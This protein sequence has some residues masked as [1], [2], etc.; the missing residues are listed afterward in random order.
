M[1]SLQS[2][3]LPFQDKT[4]L[5][6]GGA[7]YL[8]SGLIEILRNID[9]RII[10]LH[11]QDSC[12]ASVTGAA[13]ILD[14]VGDV[15]DPATWEQS[16]GGVDYIFHFAAQTSTYAANADPVADQ[17]GNVQ[18]ML[19]LL[20]SC[21]RQGRQPVVCFAS[22]VTIAGIPASL[23]V[24]ESHPDHPLTIYDLHKLMAEQYLRWYA[25]QG[26]V[27][28]VSLRLP[29]VYGP[30]PRS[31]RADRGILNQMMFRALAGET[32]TVYGTGDQVRD[33]LYVED[34]ARAFLAAALHGEILNGKYFVVGSGQGHTIAEA[35][36]LVADRV[37][38]K[39]GK[40]VLVRHIDPPHDLSPIEQRHFVADSGRFH[41]VTGWQARHT[42]VEGID[43]TL[44]AFS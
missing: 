35:M 43:Q 27:R 26:L 39:T 24:D 31:S 19:Y 36:G 14:L 44:E 7:G 3:C 5:I 4:I 22:T 37:N 12:P 13:E 32:L 2:E 8:A 17:L 11:R 16:L 41:Q 25:E 6:T 1:N 38:I 40:A 29:N 23:P 30:G 28:G 33:Y 21:R 10:R 42:L 34:A 9:C 20:E 18:P 15:R